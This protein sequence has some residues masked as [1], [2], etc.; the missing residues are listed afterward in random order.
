MRLNKRANT[1][2]ND[3]IAKAKRVQCVIRI[4]AVDLRRA[5]E[6]FDAV[7]EYFVEHGARPCILSLSF[8]FPNSSCVKIVIRESDGTDSEI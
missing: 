6:I 8:F 7:K 5:G 1:A 4:Y 2:L 3:T